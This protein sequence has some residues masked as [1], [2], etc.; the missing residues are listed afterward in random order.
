MKLFGSVVDLSIILWNVWLLPAPI[1]SSPGLRARIISPLLAGHDVV[2]L[3]EAFTHKDALREQAGY[4]FYATLGQRTFL[5]WKLRPVDS[6]LLILSKHAFEKVEKEVFTFRGGTDRFSSKGII[7]VRI[8]VD[9]VQVDIYGTHMQS[10]SSAKRTK[11][12][13]SQVQQLANFINLHSGPNDAVIVAGDMN[14]GPLTDMEFYNWAY[15][16][17][18]DKVTRTTE[19]T[20]LKSLAGL[21]DATYES[22]YWQQDINRFLV[23]NV[24]GTVYNIGKPYAIINGKKELQLSDSE[25]YAF[26]AT[27]K[28]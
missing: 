8:I 4:N 13:A 21:D 28:G 10:E 12:R 11:E 16:N 2:V 5:P 27:V 6:G 19:Y 22:P 7:M 3:N 18:E 15:E 9:G 14:M 23:R 24:E 25:R 26:N 1:S 17:Q 20:R